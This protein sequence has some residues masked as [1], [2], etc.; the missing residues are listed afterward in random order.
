MP[1]WWV[2]VLFPLLGLVGLFFLLRP[3]P[4]VRRGVVLEEPQQASA[5]DP[6][7]QRRV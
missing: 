4:T 2:D 5:R 7:G 1:V 6:Q 3:V